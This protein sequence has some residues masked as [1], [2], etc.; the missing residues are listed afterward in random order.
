MLYIAEFVTI[1][2]W[3][4]AAARGR[5]GDPCGDYKHGDPNYRI[6]DPYNCKKFWMCIVGHNQGS[7][8]LCPAG[9]SF[10]PD[11]LN[12]SCNGPPSWKVKGCFKSKG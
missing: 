9:T 1:L 2:L 10:T 5:E 8:F 11:I 12:G 3:S 6:V 4:V 7:H